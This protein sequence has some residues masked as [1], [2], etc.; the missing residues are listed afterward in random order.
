MKLKYSFKT[1]ISGVTT[2][3]S[4]SAL[5]LLGIVIG[6]TSIM[7]IISI[8]KGAEELILKEISSM[9]AE[10]IVLRPGKQPEGLTDI[11]DT[12]FADSIKIKDVEAL[13][14][15][16]NV[17]YLVDIAPAVVVPG[18]VSYG[19]ESYRPQIF[20][21]SAEFMQKMFDIDVSEG[22]LFSESDIKNKTSV[23]V[24]G[25]KVKKELFSDSDAV[26][27]SVKIKGKKFRV[28]GVLSSRGQVA[29]LNPDEIALVPYSTAQTYLLG[30]DYFNE[31]MIKAKSPEVVSR[32]VSDIEATIREMH[33]ITDPK[34]DDFFVV[35]Q[36]G[37]VSQIATIINILTIFL[38]SVVAIALVVGGIGVMNIMLVSVTERTREIGL[39]KALGATR[40]DIMT[41]FLIEAVVLTGVGGA[42]GILFGAILSFF[43]A[44]VLKNFMMLDWAFE[45]PVTA[46]LLG[47]GVSALVGL[48]FGLYPAKQASKKSPM[49]ALRYE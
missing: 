43:I 14:K 27:K 33:N 36:E 19:G 46:A 5:M 13:K 44:V 2:H 7:L 21:W 18:S 20:G 25:S 47:F 15:K 23:V 6:I 37:L 28:V 11:A 45:F 12:I 41:Q 35:T 48:I 29:F 42:I 30:I 38:S 31:V 26:G 22:V 8:G 49:E 17:P 32:T 16:S 40:K 3:K 24:I 1:A 34:K 39:R 4:R 10:T 9:G